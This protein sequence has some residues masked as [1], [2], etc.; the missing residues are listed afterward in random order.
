[1]SSQSKYRLATTLAS[2]LTLLAPDAI[3]SGF[4]INEHSAAGLGRAF[5]GEGAIAD[6]AA[7]L[8]RNP[9]AM[10]MFDKTAVSVAAT[11]V[12]PDYSVEGEFVRPFGASEA[13]HGNAGPNAVIPAAYLIQPIND[14]WA[15][16]FA[17]MTN[18]GLGTRFDDGFGADGSRMSGM[19]GLVGGETSLMSVNLNPSVAYRINESWSVGAGIDYTLATGYVDR[20]NGNGEANGA[21][22]TLANFDGA[23]NGWGWNVGTLFEINEHNRLALTYR[24][25]IDV[26]LEGD[27]HG[28]IGTVPGTSAEAE[29][30]IPMPAIA[31]L[32]GYHRLNPALAL[33]YSI[34]WT[35]W[36]AFEQLEATSSQ[37]T[38][39][40]GVCLSK[41]EQLQ[42]AMRYAVGATW[43]VS[44]EWEAR[45]G[46]AYDESAVQSEHATISLP[47]SDKWWYSLGATY[48][49]DE[50][51]SI[52][53]GMAY[54]DGEVSE[55][56]EGIAHNS[57]D[58]RYYFEG[59]REG[60][61]F[62]ASVQFNMLF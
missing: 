49:L 50:T 21:H 57:P 8:G 11:M 28:A 30:E 54:I 48:H 39:P 41:N 46:I 20:V 61:A 60:N 27:Y 2:T 16:G 29:V 9:A 42:D 51:K 44:P 10:M 25:Q 18:Y 31:E 62:L 6:S 55:V 1:M 37:C 19:A 4:Q 52:D 13:S 7:V 36:S 12:D 24:S 23:G 22:Q 43:Y 40:G 3:A 5:A 38:L 33:H 58:N 56:R 17:M 15:L 26:T 32:S 47:D 14:Q 34:M 59:S 53:L 35:D 45:A